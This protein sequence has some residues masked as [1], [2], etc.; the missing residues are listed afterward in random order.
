MAIMGGEIHISELLNREISARELKEDDKF[1]VVLDEGINGSDIVTRYTN[2][3]TWI[4][5]EIGEVKV[6]SDTMWIAVGVEAKKEV[7]HTNKCILTE[8]DKVIKLG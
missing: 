1:T 3:T 4:V 5:K 6:L 2:S 7:T 8:N